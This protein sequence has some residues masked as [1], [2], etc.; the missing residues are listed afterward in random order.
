MAR[1][2]EAED[3][4][5]VDNAL[6]PRPRLQREIESSFAALEVCGLEPLRDLPAKGRWQGL[7]FGDGAPFGGSTNG[8]MVHGFLMVRRTVAVAVPSERKA[9]AGI[10]VHVV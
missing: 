6:E 5:K 3:A 9:P 2:L 4:E 8:A 10:G 7:R 1:E